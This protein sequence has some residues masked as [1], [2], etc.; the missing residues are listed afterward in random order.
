[1]S[2]HFDDE[3]RR[4]LDEI[5]LPLHRPAD[6]N[7]VLVRAG[8]RTPL[9]HV[10]RRRQRIM[11]PV[12]LAATFAVAAAVATILVTRG[13]TPSLTQQALAAIGA[14]PMTHIIVEQGLND[15]LIDLRNGKQTPAPIRIELWSEPRHGVVFERTSLGRTQTIFLPV[16]QQP[17]SALTSFFFTDYRAKLRSGDVRELGKGRIDGQAVYWLETPAE[18]PG[19]TLRIAVS[20]STFKPVHTELWQDGHRVGGSGVRVLTIE[21]LPLDAAL[22]RR[23]AVKEVPMIGFDPSSNP[24]ITLAQAAKQMKRPPVVPARRIGGLRRVWVGPPRWQIG[25]D[26]MHQRAPAG[27]LLFYGTT[28]QYTT[29]NDFGTRPNLNAS[30][31]TITEYAHYN[32]VLARPFGG[33]G[34]FPT[35]GRAL[36]R[37]SV[38]TLRHNGLWIT[39]EASS[40]RLALDA[41]KAIVAAR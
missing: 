34:S 19:A 4:L 10:R 14:G 36:L 32:P 39:I 33:A 20:Q 24:R 18:T 38:L 40:P 2:V 31:I 11:R 26:P 16:S 9:R 5:A 35:D 3:T 15:R 17:T 37:G 12:A 23:T 13:G 25:P 41:G 1:M 27:V 21:S 28:E 6:W 8:A 29:V 30:H 7:D 22:F